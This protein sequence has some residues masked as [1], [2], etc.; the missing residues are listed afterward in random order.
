MKRNEIQ[1]LLQQLP[2]PNPYT[3]WV[4]R[5]RRFELESWPWMQPERLAVYDPAFGWHLAKSFADE[6]LELPNTVLQP[7]IWRANRYL[8]EPDPPDLPI[9]M[10]Q[11]LDLAASQQQFLLLR[12]LLICDDLNL[13]SIA[14]L[15]GY[16]FEVVNLYESLFWNC[17]ERKGERNYLAHIC[18]EA[19]AGELRSETS[20]QETSR[21]NLLELAHKQPVAARVLK[22]A[23]MNHVLNQE[24]ELPTLYDQISKSL[25]NYAFRGL[26]KGAIGEKEN[27]A[28]KPS[29]RILSRK[30]D[31]RS[32]KELE[33]QRLSL[34]EAM[35]RAIDQVRGA[36]GVSLS[37]CQS[38]SPD[39][40]K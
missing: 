33:R 25:L 13:E 24:I 8:L 39:H 12:A 35:K 28:L 34:P 40:E 26:T 5:E 1:E 4:N 2:K 15:C 20:A 7:A 38:V 18:C 31:H 32:N 11:M 27:P 9:A 14:Q 29:L 3:R 10:A 37:V 22:A 16:D 17:R 19:T 23:Q 21:V 6:H 30:L 36:A